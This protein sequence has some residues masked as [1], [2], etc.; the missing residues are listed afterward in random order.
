[1]ILLASYNSAPGKRGMLKKFFL[2]NV[3]KAL[4]YY[5]RFDL[6]YRYFL[7]P[8][9]N[10]SVGL[11]IIPPNFE[12][13]MT[14]TA[15]DIILLDA[16]DKIPD[17]TIQGKPL[18]L[19]QL[20]YM[21]S[22]NLLTTNIEIQGNIEVAKD[23]A[24]LCHSIQVDWEDLLARVC[25]DQFAHTFTVIAKQP[26]QWGKYSVDTWLIDFK[27]FLQEE[28]K[29]V[30]T[31]VEVTKFLDKIDTLRDDTERLFLQFSQLKSKLG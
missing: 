31:S 24:N 12:F 14:F 20:T 21:T 9:T 13:I 27:S 29:I 7:S 10:K 16:N 5:L 4:N 30:P 22:S 23:L 28:A 18:E 19:L 25:G 2:K 3:E 8:L 17:C 26:L 1:M 6:D 11:K 15:D